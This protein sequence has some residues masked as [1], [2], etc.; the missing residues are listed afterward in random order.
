MKTCA[1]CNDIQD[2]SEF[3]KN[4]VESD[5]KNRYCKSCTSSTQRA[6]RARNPAKVLA[7]SNQYYQDNKAEVRAKMKERYKAKW[8]LPFMVPPR[9]ATTRGW[10]PQ[11][12]TKPVIQFNGLEGLYCF[13]KH[14]EVWYLG[15]S[16]DLGS[17]LFQHL[18]DIERWG[19]LSEYTLKVR[20]SSYL[21]EQD[22]LEKKLIKK[23]LP[24][25]NK[26]I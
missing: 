18:H 24:P 1:R 11:S 3:T 17:R 21:G 4:K 22:L 6:Y 13:Y 16:K 7:R 2:L 26:H 15:K 8:V 9:V 25:S 5:K 19:S 23:L 20:V 14:G 12:V 10:K